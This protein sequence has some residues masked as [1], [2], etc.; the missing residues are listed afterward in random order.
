MTSLIIVIKPPGFTFLQ[1]W[2][3][4]LYFQTTDFKMVIFNLFDSYF[5]FAGHFGCYF[6]W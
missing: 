5:V 3:I 2:S 1:D 4:I 6:D